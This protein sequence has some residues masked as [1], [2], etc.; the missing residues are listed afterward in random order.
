M[1]PTDGDY[2]TVTHHRRGEPVAPAHLP[3]PPFD[4]AAALLPP[5]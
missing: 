2:R 3:V 5:A 4:V 1:L